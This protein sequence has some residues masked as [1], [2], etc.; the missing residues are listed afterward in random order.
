MKFRAENGVNIVCLILS[1][2]CPWI[3]LGTLGIPTGAAIALGLLAAIYGN[4]MP[5]EQ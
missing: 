1:A 2:G 3:A 5:P 4:N